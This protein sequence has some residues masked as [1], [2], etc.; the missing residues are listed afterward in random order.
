MVT[1][2]N[3]YAIMFADVSGSTMLYDT[4]GDAI[5]EK[6]IDDCI[7]LMKSVTESN[8][9]TVIKTIGD[10]VMC[11]FSNANDAANAALE[12]QTTLENS[13]LGLS[14]RVGLQYGN[15][16]ERDGDIYGD[17][18]N[19]A[20]RMAGVAKAKQIITTEYL[21]SELDEKLAEHARLFDTAKIKGKDEELKIYQINWEEEAKV[22]QFASTADISKL[23]AAASTIV[24]KYSG[25]EKI[26]TNDDLDSAV[27]IGKDNNSHIAV[28]APFASRSHVN[29]EFRRGK[30]VLIDH[31]T[32][33]TYVRFK[34]QNDLF[35]RREELPL[36]GEG[37][38]SLGEIITED[39]PASIS[40]S[41]IQK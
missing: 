26:L 19:V 12:M 21:V 40:F 41:I 29:L 2:E 8:H 16:I 5:A 13:D 15:A 10:E 3:N 6:K 22:T 30:F 23:T 34:G 28:N 7:K 25:K 9:G 11:S 33:G 37:I 17:A 36:M 32:N 14:I 27:I 35:I 38:I 4:L 18:V 1:T 20:A 39:G 31:S 24:L